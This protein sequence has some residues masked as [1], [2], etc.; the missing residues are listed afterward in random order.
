MNFIPHSLTSSHVMGEQ[1]RTVVL[2]GEAQAELALALNGLEAVLTLL[3]ADHGGDPVLSPLL[4]RNLRGGA[5][6]LVARARLLA[7]GY[8]PDAYGF[9]TDDDAA[10]QV[11]DLAEKLQGA[12]E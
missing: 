3:D 4:A 11:I 9:D 8:G 6:V 12:Q 1:A 5:A 2:T 10:Q 7:D